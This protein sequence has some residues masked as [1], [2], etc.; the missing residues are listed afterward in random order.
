MKYT[1]LFFLIIAS[2][3]M[4]PV[5]AHAQ[6]NLKVVVYGDGLTS[7]QQLQ[8]NESYAVKLGYKLRAIGYTN[9]DVVNMSV[10][11]QTTSSAVDDLPEVLA[12]RP[13]IV[14]VQLGNNEMLRNINTDVIY[15]NLGNIIGTLQQ[16]GIYVVLIGIKAPESLGYAYVKQLELVYRRLVDFYR[17]AFY[18]HALEGISGNPDLTLADGYYPNGKAM[19]FMVENTYLMVDAGLRW[20]WSVLKDQG[21]LQD[22]SREKIALPPPMPTNVE[23]VPQ[24]RNH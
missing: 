10:P 14:V 13:D 19:D 21:G 15:K 4:P 22:E 12:Q 6:G 11:A 9:V 3:I 20:K 18:P 5:V 7:G 2:I 17:I 23:P 24:G 1:G 16:K 8:S